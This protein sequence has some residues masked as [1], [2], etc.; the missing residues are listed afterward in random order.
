MAKAL[1]TIV[2]KGVTGLF[3]AAAVVIGATHLLGNDRAGAFQATEPGTIDLASARIEDLPRPAETAPIPAEALL[4]G[5]PAPSMPKRPVAVAPPAADC[6]P[7]LSATLLGGATVRLTLAAPCDAGARVEMRHEGLIFD[8]V[9]DVN[10]GV[11]VD[12]PALARI[13]GFEATVAGETLKTIAALPDFD[14]YARVALQWAGESGLQI[15]ALE[16]GAGH[17]DEGHVWQDAPG[18][19]LRAVRA[20]GGFLARLGDDSL[21][22]GRMAEIYVFPAALMQRDGTVRLSVEARV[23][24][25]SCG[26]SV[27]GQ[28][29]Q[30]GDDGRL[31]TTL[32]TLEIPDCDAVGDILVLKNLLRDMKIASN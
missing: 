25:F 7:A 32:L 30:P 26:K 10:G 28:V 3:A 16:F 17:G 4:P 29:M 5:K 21:R 13:A 20:R 11:S 1:K 9:T 18:S 8:V 12:V 24:A 22:D 15:H 19:S 2:T 27:E 23:N 31:Q 6:T 14:S